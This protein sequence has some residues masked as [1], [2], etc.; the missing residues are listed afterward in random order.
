MLKIRKARKPKAAIKSSSLQ[1]EYQLVKLLKQ[2]DVLVFPVVDLAPRLVECEF[3]VIGLFRFLEKVFG[4]FRKEF[5]K[6]VF[7]GL[8]ISRKDMVRQFGLLDMLIV[9]GALVARFQGN[10]FFFDAR[11]LND[12][13]QQ[14]PPVDMGVLALQS[15]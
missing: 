10:F 11:S 4:H 8:A 1:F 3:F 9:A 7:D 14:L 6:I 15:R 13:F 5:G 2:L 12:V